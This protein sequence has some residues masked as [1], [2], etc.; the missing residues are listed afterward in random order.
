M[1]RSKERTSRAKNWLVHDHQEG[2]E[3]G[4]TF[5]NREIIHVAEK[6]W[7]RRERAGGVK[8][9]TMCELFGHRKKMNYTLRGMGRLLPRG[10]TS[11]DSLQLL[12]S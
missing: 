5:R 12:W 3:L 1:G 10:V 11:S 4:C 7:T 8:G 9:E 2:G 6:W